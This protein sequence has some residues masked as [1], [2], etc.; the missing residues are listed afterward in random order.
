MT[1]TNAKATA[2]I[3]G[4]INVGKAKF[5]LAEAMQH[6]ANVYD[7]LYLLQEQQLDYYRELGNILLQARSLFKSDKLFGQYIAGS[8]L[9]CMSRQDRSDAM[10]IATEWAQVQKLNANGALESLGVS[11]IRKRCKAATKPKASAGNTSKGKAKAEPKAEAKAATDGP[12]DT[13]FQTEAELAAFVAQ[14][15]KENGLDNVQFLIALKAAL[16]A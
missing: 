12:S 6:G 4:T 13:K 1:N 10:F 15:L 5:T 7:K 8:A 16:A 11:A 9:G 14:S 3:N 2:S